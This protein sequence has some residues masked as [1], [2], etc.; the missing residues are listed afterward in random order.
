MSQADSGRRAGIGF[1]C[2]QDNCTGTV[3]FDLEAAPSEDFQAVCP[4]CHRAYAFN[5][6]L[7]GK[8]ER[9]MRLIDAI[10]GAEDLLA[11]CTVSVTTAAGEVRIPYAM[12][13]TRLNTRLK[14]DIGGKPVDIHL[15]VEPSSPETFR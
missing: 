7:R 3:E 11:D 6:A 10:R 1:H 8:L 15:L 2:P 4:V 5:P 12:L 13:L 14:L 9:M